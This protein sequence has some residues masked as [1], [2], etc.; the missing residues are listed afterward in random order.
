MRQIQSYKRL[1]RSWRAVQ[2]NARTSSSLDVRKEID[3]FAEDATRN[4][5]SLSARLSA[6][7]FKF[8]AARGIPIAKVNPDGSKNKKKFRPIVLAPLQSRIVQRSILD[9]LGT[10]EE[11]K[12]YY[13]NEYSFGGIRKKK[14]ALAAVPA[15]IHAV[16]A[17]IGD[18]AT[19]VAFADI[20]AFFTKIPKPLVTSVISKTTRDAEFTAFFEEAIAVEL[21]NLVD[22]REK[23]ALFPIYEIGV[24]QGNSLSPLLGNILLHDFDRQMNEGDCRCVRYIDDFIILAPSSSAAKARM[25]KA[26]NI[27]SEV[28]MTLSE[29]KTLAVPLRVEE[30]FDFLGIE[31][32]SG[33]IRPAQ[34]AIERF[35]KNI[36]ANF[37]ESL[38]VMR[39]TERGKSIPKRHSLIATI[40]RVAS[41][42]RGWGKHY[43]FCNDDDLFRRIDLQ[44]QKSVREFLGEY[45]NIRLARGADDA[46]SLL[47]IDELSKQSRVP[48][49]WPKRALNKS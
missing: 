24:A 36:K 20:R 17:A 45:K 13:E 23:S 16:L 48:L 46:S 18:G 3:D 5:R 9:A 14:D 4:I 15:A 41:I 10:V 28:D 31:F 40:G 11:L 33:R 22:L 32:N 38:K 29:E 2:E 19:H 35:E 30:K 8:E 25:K 39:N 44:V 43:K 34:K 21:T 42:V 26:I 37:T 12:P 1:E 27:L 6:R 49:A 7:T 47:G